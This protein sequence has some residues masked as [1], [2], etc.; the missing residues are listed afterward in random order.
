MDVVIIDRGAFDKMM[1][2]LEIAAKKID[3]GSNRYSKKKE[4]QNWLEGDEV[5]AILNVTKRTLQ[6]YRSNGMLPYTQIGYKMYYLSE[7]ILNLID[8]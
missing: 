2:S 7:D 1:S 5:C 4:M 6:T 3:E 8:K